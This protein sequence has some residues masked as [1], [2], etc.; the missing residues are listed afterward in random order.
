MN[1]KAE[2]SA[3]MFLDNEVEIDLACDIAEGITRIGNEQHDIN[4]NA[5]EECRGATPYVLKE[6]KKDFTEHPHYSEPMKLAIVAEIFHYIGTETATSRLKFE[7][8]KRAQEGIQ[9][10]DGVVDISPEKDE[11]QPN[12]DR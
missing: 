12:N 2:R 5:D 10:M 9:G 3:G 8:Y 4:C 11:E 7:L 1:A 6:L